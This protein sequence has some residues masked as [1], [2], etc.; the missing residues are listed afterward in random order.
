[1]RTLVSVARVRPLERAGDWAGAAQALEAAVD[2]HQS[3]PALRLRLARAYECDHRWEEAA[4]AHRAAL[5]LGDR[6]PR[7]FA[8]LG[9][10]LE[11]QRQW[12]EA[13]H[14]Y[15]AALEV[16]DRRP[17]TFAR[18]GRALERQHRWDEAEE[19]YRAA[20]ALGDRRPRTFARLGR[21][22]ERQ[23]R[24]D[25]AADA[26]R[27]ALALDGG[28]ARWHF[29]LGDA[30]ARN[31][32]W[33]DAVDAYRAALALDDSKEEWHL[34]LG[35]ALGRL[36]DR[37]GARR[38]YQDVL[39]RD[40]KTTDVDRSLLEA[41]IGRFPSRRRYA[42][43][44]AAH[45]DEIRERASAVRHEPS[46][47][48]PRIWVYWDK[49]VA[50]APAI[51][52]RCHRELLRYHSADEVVALDEGLVPHYVE[53]P[54]VARRRTAQNPTKFA[55]VLRLELLSRYGGVWLDATC[56]PR[57]RV[58]DLLPELLPSGF[59]AFRY[60]AAR[61]SSW[62]LAS[63]PNHP[64]VAMI[65]EA[66]YV[67]WEH[68]A[69]PIDY[70]PLHHLFESL[71]YLADDFR[72]SYEATPWRSSHPPSRFARV[73]LEPYDRHRYNELLDACFVHKLTYKFPPERAKPDTLLAHLMRG[74]E[75][76]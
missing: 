37:D 24:W 64:L 75:P 38:T 73:M 53:I 15:R 72:E 18:L 68:F 42:R 41:D 43:F 70:F 13:A 76:A 45:L 28:R 9:R 21:A 59:F 69:R 30:L 50:N 3:D 1:M 20:L 34:Q 14:A 23:R 26:Y 12:D 74:D 27:A 56:F 39:E 11:R 49:G 40:P 66:Q 19:A 48:R 62:L 35:T 60:R 6:R 71:Y 29:R 4:Q 31:H 54:E 57:Q 16:D 2:R 63:E 22:L 10:A 36:G 47:Q 32:R 61:I 7:T 25:E 51:V 58:L 5:A 8:R 46:A 65:R 33:Q 67:Y 55:D 52:R 17:R 44:V